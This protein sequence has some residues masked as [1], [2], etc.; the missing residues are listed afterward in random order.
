MSDKIISLAAEAAKR[1]EYTTIDLQFFC[2]D[3]D[4]EKFGG[5]DKCKDFTDHLDQMI[6]MCAFCGW[7]KRQRENGTP[8][9]AQWFCQ[10]CIKDGDV[11]P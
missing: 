11:C 7:W 8:D 9:G 3:E 6:F 10:E 2:E 1:L 5:L 4:N